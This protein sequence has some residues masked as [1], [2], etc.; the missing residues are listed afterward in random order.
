[1]KPPPPPIKARTLTIRLQPVS[2]RMELPPDPVSLLLPNQSRNTRADLYGQCA[3]AF[4]LN[5][6]K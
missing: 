1:M 4:F 5:Y 3:L 6:L 2:N